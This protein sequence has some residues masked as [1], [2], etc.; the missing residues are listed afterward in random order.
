MFM[1]AVEQCVADPNNRMEVAKL[2]VGEKLAVM[3]HTAQA[4]GEVSDWEECKSF[5]K[6]EIG[7]G[8]NFE[9]AWRQSDLVQYDW[10]TIPQS[11]VHHYK[12]QYAAIQER[13]RRKP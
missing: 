2:R 12:S 10:T 1:E 13:S 5:L 3:I 4:R 6:Q 8:V 7:I 9:Q 11:F